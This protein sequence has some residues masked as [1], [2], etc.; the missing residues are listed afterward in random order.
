VA[1]QDHEF[2]GP[3]T[4]NTTVLSDIRVLPGGRD[5]GHV[6]RQECEPVA[7]HAL[8]R[9]SGVN[10]EVPIWIGNDLAARRGARIAQGRAA[11]APSGHTYTATA[12]A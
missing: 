5:D 6:A 3:F 4:P 10:D 12:P 8:E 11:N 2:A 1:C 7:D 9:V